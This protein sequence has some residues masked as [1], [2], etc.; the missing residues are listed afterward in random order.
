MPGYVP[1]VFEDITTFIVND[2]VVWALVAYWELLLSRRR[3]ETACKYTLLQAGPDK[4]RTYTVKVYYP[5]TH[6]W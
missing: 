4:T 5:V 6:F 3:A 2:L 1:T